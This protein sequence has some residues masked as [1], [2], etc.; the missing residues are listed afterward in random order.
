[1]TTTKKKGEKIWVKCVNLGRD[2]S[3][4]D[5]EAMFKS[6]KMEDLDFDNL[7]GVS[8]YELEKEPV[9]YPSITA[10]KK[11]YSQFYSIFEYW[12]KNKD[13]TDDQVEWI[14]K[15]VLDFTLKFRKTPLHFNLTLMQESQ[16]IM[17]FIVTQFAEFLAKKES[18]LRQCA[19]SD[20]RKYFLPTPR[21]KEQ[22]FCAERCRN[23]I[24]QKR[25]REKRKIT[26]FP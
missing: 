19:A 20:C 10:F 15:Q 24:A 5:I 21:G 18:E 16:M 25:L 6:I 14:D 9:I 13:L 11:W 12:V 4:V 2:P 3:G 26:V 1:M 7:G 17:K 22:L 8:H 23:R